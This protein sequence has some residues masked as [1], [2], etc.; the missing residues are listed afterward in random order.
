MKNKRR[1]VCFPMPVKK[2]FVLWKYSKFILGQLMELANCPQNT[3]NLRNR[4]LM[5]MDLET[6]RI[7]T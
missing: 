4:T 7:L 3:L 5:K 2:I 6:E 1:N